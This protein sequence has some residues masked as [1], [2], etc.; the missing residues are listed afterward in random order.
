[1]G[2]RRMEESL[3]RGRERGD[4]LTPPRETSIAEGFGLPIG[5]S[6]AYKKPC[7]ASNTTSMP[8]VGGRFVRYLE[9]WNQSEGYAVVR[10]TIL[11]PKGLAEWTADIEANFHPKTWQEFCE[12]FFSTAIGTSTALPKGPGLLNFVT[13]EQYY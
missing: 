3:G 13:E 10:D 8:E 4:V 12:E 2:P 9:P 7:I 1:M 11:D 6:L 5:E